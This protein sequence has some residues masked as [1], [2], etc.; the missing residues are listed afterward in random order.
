MNKALLDIQAIITLIPFHKTLLV[1]D[2]VY[3][4]EDESE[5][6]LHFSRS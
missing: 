6:M 2:D 3:V 4:S 5:A 1:A